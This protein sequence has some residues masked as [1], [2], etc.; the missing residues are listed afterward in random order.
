RDLNQL[1][2]GTR[3]ANPTDSINYVRPYQGYGDILSTTNGAISNYNSLQARVTKRMQ[4]GGTLG[5]S[6]TW[7]KGLT[8]AQSYSYLPENSRNLRGDYGRENFN[9]NQILVISYV[10][11]LPFWRNGDQ[12]YK[13]LLG[14]WQLSGV[15]NIS[16]GLPINVT[17]PTGTDPAGDGLGGTTGPGQSQRPN[18]VGNPFAVGVEQNQFLNA[19]S[20]AVPA[21]GFGNRQAYGITTRTFNNWDVSI[22]KGFPIN[23]NTGFDFRAEMF[24][25]PNH[26]SPF[27]YSTQ[28]GSS[29]FGQ[30]TSAT[31]PRTVEF[32]LR[33][34]F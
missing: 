14:G 16:S 13:K 10:Y 33:F 18:L 26:M 17:D 4:R 22:Q 1:Q 23:E 20:F 7:S 19:A 32:A 3:Q 21:S 27:G 6:Y 9:R 2:P 28:V 29:N 11:P 34:H 30:V 12:L 5:V 15:T 25:F 8:D 24:N 31:D